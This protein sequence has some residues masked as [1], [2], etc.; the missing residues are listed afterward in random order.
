[1]LAFDQRVSCVYC[2][3][4]TGGKQCL[5]PLPCGCEESMQSCH[6]NI[7]Q[8]TTGLC[9]YYINPRLHLTQRRGRPTPLMN[10]HVSHCVL[11]GISGITSKRVRPT[12]NSNVQPA[13]NLST[14]PDKRFRESAVARS[15]AEPSPHRPDEALLN[16]ERPS[17]PEASL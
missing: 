2:G 4:A 14:R 3:G 1:M 11:S 5:T 17:P 10:S 9:M 15:S 8:I 7:Q 6:P 13:M 12:S 16:I